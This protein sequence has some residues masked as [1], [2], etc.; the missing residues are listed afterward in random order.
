M[1]TT[2]AGLQGSGKGVG[3]V[4]GLA[5]PV[6]G[7][8]IPSCVADFSS[9]LLAFFL[10]L[11]DRTDGCFSVDGH[12]FVG[13]CNGSPFFFCLFVISAEVSP[14]VPRVGFCV[15]LVFVDWI[16]AIV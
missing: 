6:V 11:S 9:L 8:V 12:G 7:G 15:D 10:R 3:L 4:H 1:D 13:G 5:L 2:R 16:L 14:L